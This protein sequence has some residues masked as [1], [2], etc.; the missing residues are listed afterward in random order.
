MSATTSKSISVKSMSLDS[1]G[2]KES[3]DCSVSTGGVCNEAGCIG[4]AAKGTDDGC[5]VSGF[6]AVW[7]GAG[8]AVGAAYSGTGDVSGT[9]SGVM[10]SACVFNVGISASTVPETVGCPARRA[11][12]AILDDSAVFRKLR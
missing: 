2:T 3:D 6:E 9:G 11:P 4:G 8:M 5:T 10:I 7:S 12:K 1:G